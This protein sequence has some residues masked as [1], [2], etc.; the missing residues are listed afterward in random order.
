M[1]KF[2]DTIKAFQYND[3]VELDRTKPPKMLDLSQTTEASSQLY[4]TY[5]IEARFATQ[6]Q[7]TPDD[8]ESAVDHIRREIAEYVYGEIN[9]ELTEWF[10]DLRH[11]HNIRHAECEAFYKILDKMK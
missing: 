8:V 10:S 4:H 6:M 1:T 3:K 11:S 9:K 2:L 7:I 5:R